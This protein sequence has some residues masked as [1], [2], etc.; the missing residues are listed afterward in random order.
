MS[1]AMRRARAVMASAIQQNAE[2][3]AIK[4]QRDAAFLA[5]WR[6]GHPELADMFA[7]IDSQRRRRSAP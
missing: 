5:S 2:A 6:S 3:A 4:R 7:Q 1:D